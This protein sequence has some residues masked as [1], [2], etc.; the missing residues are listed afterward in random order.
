MTRSLE[1]STHA[2]LT[3]LDTV[4]YGR[5]IRGAQALEFL[6][7]PGGLGRQP[8]VDSLDDLDLVV[9]LARSAFLA[10]RAL[11]LGHLPEVAALILSL[12]FGLHLVQAVHLGGIVEDASDV[13]ETVARLGL[14]SV[15]VIE[16]VEL[17]ADALASLGG[18][19]LGLE[20]LG[21]NTIRRSAIILTSNIGVDGIAKRTHCTYSS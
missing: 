18:L 5:D 2:E 10:I 9:R 19:E 17:D 8:L 13:V 16:S 4:D 1:R 15:F 21:E 12:V 7:K 6:A 3:A 14:R 11:A 20:S